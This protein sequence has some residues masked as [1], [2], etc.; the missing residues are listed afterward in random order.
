MDFA[1]AAMN[2]VTV[3]S[4]SRIRLCG[5]R[6]HVFQSWWRR[7]QLRSLG[8]DG[9]LRKR[10]PQ[11]QNDWCCI[12]VCL[13]SRQIN[14]LRRPLLKMMSRH[15]PDDERFPKNCR[16]HIIVETYLDT[17]CEFSP[18]L[19]AETKYR[20]ESSHCMTFIASNV[21]DI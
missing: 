15:M 16:Q 11:D 1:K 12:L 20:S 6:F 17:G 9:D 13:C 8:S 19:W 10:T 4:P 14:E 2:A 18:D 21:M 5:Y 7:M 3:V